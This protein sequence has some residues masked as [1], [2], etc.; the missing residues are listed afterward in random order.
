M[1]GKVESGDP[2]PG[3]RSVEV[4]DPLKKKNM[5]R[6]LYDWVMHWAETRYGLPALFVLAFCESSFFPIPPDVLLIALCVSIPAK[7]L[8][9]A[10]VATVGSVLGGVFG[11]YIGFALYESVGEPI[12]AF[13]HAQDAFEKVRQY[14]NEHPFMYIAISGFTPIP[15]KVFTIAAGVCKVDISTLVF[16][17]IVGRAGRF[18]LVGGM[19]WMFGPTIKDFIDKYFNLC[20]IGFT[21][22]VI[23]GIL[24]I[25]VIM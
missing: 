8:R 13:F 16:A 5:I 4:A 1:E 24:A 3:S 14:Y 23:V 19:I 15:Y 11:Y 10:L 7:A 2:N 22:L 21:V 9:Y 18:F 25:K 20:A 6:R 17:S 12:I